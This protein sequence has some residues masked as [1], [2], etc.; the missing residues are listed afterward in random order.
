VR[1]PYHRPLDGL[2]AIKQTNRTH[3]A[4]FANERKVGY[5]RLS[6]EVGVKY[7]GERGLKRVRSAAHNGREVLENAVGHAN[8]LSPSQQ[9][10]ANQRLAVFGLV[11]HLTKAKIVKTMPDEPPEKE[12]SMA[13]LRKAL[14]V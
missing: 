13:A 2:Q 5:R 12:D 11:D 8:D 3:G 7:A 1:H 6:S 10:N 9:R 4:V 14:G